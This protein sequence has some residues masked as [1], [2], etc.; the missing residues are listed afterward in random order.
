MTAPN[1]VSNSALPLFAGRVGE[2]YS[3]SAPVVQIGSSRFIRP[4]KLLNQAKTLFVDGAP[5]LAS[6]VSL[7]LGTAI[8]NVSGVEFDL[9]NPLT[10]LAPVDAQ[11]IAR[12]RMRVDF[13]LP[14]TYP[15]LDGVPVHELGI[16]I[17]GTMA[18]IGSE[19]VPMLTKF[20]GVGLT[21]SVLLEFAFSSAAS[22][23]GDKFEQAMAA[24][25][26]AQQAAAAA[27]TESSAAKAESA[28]AKLESAAA[29]TDATTAKAD[30]AT[31][32]TDAV[33]A[34]ADA[35]AAKADSTTALNTANI[36]KTTAD[37]SKAESTTALNT[38]NQAKNTADT[39]KNTADGATATANTAK[40]T[41]DTAKSTAD[42]AKSTADTAK[43]TA[44]TA[45]NTADA[46][47]LESADAKSKIDTAVA[48][49]N[50]SLAN[51]NTA[52]ETANQAAQTA[53]AASA[54]VADKVSSTG[55][56]FTG[57]LKVK[58]I[59]E[60]EAPSRNVS[61]A[62]TLD[63]SLGTIHELVLIGNVTSLAFSNI[64]DG[65]Y[66]MTLLIKQDGTG[67]R[68]FAFPASFNWGDDGAVTLATAANKTTPVSLMTR[69]G[70]TGW[71]AFGGAK[72]Y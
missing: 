61:G 20:A 4:P 62:V 59:T 38:A 49:V 10:E 71:M 11:L 28:A 14:D 34:K 16:K 18:L 27:K 54:S 21:I 53:N 5:M 6:A 64:P 72:G 45:K 26:A 36:A 7:S 70:G 44:D 56:T 50:T 68:T 58:T 40:N 1:Q 9:L 31:A 33:A 52:M 32:K 15:T 37:S 60:T 24:A 25:I 39:A 30:S 48:N 43:G 19:P 47:K 3:V 46:A 2:M 12:N 63:C 69:N 42:T 67:N 17:N 55:A 35:A 22:S 41:A 66:S 65:V 13:R 8:Y 51:A 23:G 57:P 29:K